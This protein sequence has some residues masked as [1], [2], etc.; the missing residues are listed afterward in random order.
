[1]STNGMPY[2]TGSDGFT[3]E[4]ISRRTMTVI[5]QKDPHVISRKFV[6]P[7][8]TFS[9][10]HQSKKG[11]ECLDVTPGGLGVSCDSSCNLSIWQTD[12]GE[13]RR[14]LKGHVGNV[15]SCKFFPSG[16]VVLSAGA[17]MQMKIWSAET[18]KEAACLIGHTAAILDTA[19]VE[20]GRNIVSCGRDGTARLWDVGKQECLYAWSDLGGEINCC[21]L[22]TINTSV[23]L[24]AP[25][26]SPSD[27]EI[28]TEGKMLLLGSEMGSLL[29]VGLHSRQR[30]FEMKCS[31]AINC[32]AFLSDVHAVCGTHDSRIVIIDL[33]NT[34]EPLRQW[35]ESRGAIL[36]LLPYKQ[37]LF[38]STGDGS[39]YYVNEEFEAMVEFTG[40]DCDPVN[41]IACD[42]THIY[43][44][45][46]DGWIR[47]YSLDDM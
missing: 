33:R 6:S 14:E 32:C 34:S 2:V 29:G 22:A 3:V 15:Y 30:V 27:R 28:L 17:D 5:Y 19:I 31:A 46:R 35:K 36:S 12:S 7:V 21:S 9:T 16:I 47:K 23:D 20:R 4:N 25:S 24:G 18:G 10:I 43:G 38:I 44:G 8:I 37:G 41:R 45:C 13:K 39:L 42:Q 1:M 26:V 11:V 40:S